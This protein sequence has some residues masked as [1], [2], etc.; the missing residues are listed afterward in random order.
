ME[1]PM[2]N[3]KDFYSETMEA[4]RKCHNTFQVLKENNCQPQILYQVK[5]S[6]ESEKEI[7]TFS[8]KEKLKEFIASRPTLKDWPKEVLQTQRK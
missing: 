8:N 6:F 3:T 4:S 1:T 2:Q 7:N 5:L